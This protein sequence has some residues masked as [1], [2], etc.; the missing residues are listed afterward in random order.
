MLT[1]GHPQVY[2]CQLG[3]QLWVVLSH[4]APVDSFSL[5]QPTVLIKY[6][7][8][9]LENIQASS[10]PAQP[11]LA[12]QGQLGR[13]RWAG[14]PQRG[15]GIRRAVSHLFSVVGPTFANRDLSAQ[16]CEEKEA[17]TGNVNYYGPSHTH[18]VGKFLKVLVWVSVWNNGNSLLWEWKL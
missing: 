16:S 9:G 11:S 14:T 13:A 2:S 6:P 10:G 3:T 15:V 4:M 7:Y 5:P 18:Q 12:P 17:S 1:G 8:P